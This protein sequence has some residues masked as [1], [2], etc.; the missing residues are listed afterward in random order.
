M[1]RLTTGRLTRSRWNPWLP[2]D[3][4]RWKHL[5]PSSFFQNRMS[6]WK[7]N[8]SYHVIQFGSHCVHK[9]CT[10]GAKIQRTYNWRHPRLSRRLLRLSFEEQNSQTLRDQLCH[11]SSDRP[12]QT[13]SSKLFYKKGIT[14]TK[15][16]HNNINRYIVFTYTHLPE[17]FILFKSSNVRSFPPT[18]SLEKDVSSL[19]FSGAIL[20]N[21][22]PLVNGMTEYTPAGTFWR[23]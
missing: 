20:S 8:R 7:S 5:Y 17:N 11:R 23:K 13:C 10:E 18:F 21:H 22:A 12:L 16:E 3:G 1:W 4:V 19:A 15:I 14:F 6:L 2:F 9:Y